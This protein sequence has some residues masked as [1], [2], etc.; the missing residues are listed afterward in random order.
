MNIV[1]LKLINKFGEKCKS[2]NVDKIYGNTALIFACIN[3]MNDVAL[4]LIDNFNEKCKPD[5]V[6]NKNKTAKIKIVTVVPN[7]IPSSLCLIHNAIN[8]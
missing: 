8:T 6:N 1:A 5:K 7:N 2:N 4:K 3:K